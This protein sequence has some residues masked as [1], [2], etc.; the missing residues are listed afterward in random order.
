MPLSR[1][2][3]RLI[4]L[5]VV[6]L[7]LLAIVLAM[8]YVHH[9]HE[10]SEMQAA[11]IVKGAMAAIDDNLSARIAGLQMLAKSP[12]GDDAAHWKALYQQAQGYRDSFGSH[13]VLADA[14]MHMRFN[15]RVPFGA[16]LPALPQPSGR[17]AAKTARDTLKPA[18]GDPFM[19]PIAGEPLVAIAAPSIRDE[20]LSHMLLTTIE[21]RLL[22]AT[23][24]QMVL[25]AGWAV[26]L[27]DSADAVIARHG[28]AQANG[29]AAGE[30]AQRFVGKS[31]LAPWSV[32]L[33]IPR[34]IYF[35]PVIDA[36]IALVLAVLIATTL[37]FLG[38]KWA[39]RRLGTAVASL[40]EAPGQPR[41][42]PEI[43]EI[44]HARR[45]LD[46]ALAQRNQ[47]EAARRDS[48]QR[49]RTQIE[50]GAH[51]VALSESRLRG[52]FDSA[53]DTILTADASQTII[54]ANPAAARM[55][56]CSLDRL[57]GAPLERL[58]PARYHQQH[59]RDV[60]AF[61]DTDVQ[62]RQMA[63]QRPVMGLRSD[64]E[65]FPIEAAISHLT[66]DGQRLYTVILRDITQRVRD[67]AALQR[68]ADIVETSGDAIL[69]RLSDGT[70]VTWN[71]AAQQLF[72]YTQEEMV[73]SSVERLYSPHTKP[74]ERNLAARVVRGER[75]VNIDTLR[76]HKDGT[77]IPVAITMSAVRDQHGT[78]VATTAILR[79]IT[80][81]I[82]MDAELER[83]LR[84]Q[85]QAEATMR[86]SRD[87]L[88]ELSS[89]LQTIREDEKTRIAREL[90]DELGQA[91]TALKMDAA[92]ITSAL[93]PTAVALR[94]RTDD[95]TQ[96]ID[97][98]VMSVRRIAADLR[99]V[100]L[101]NLGLVPTLEWLAKDFAQRTGIHV[102]LDIDDENLEVEGDPATAVFRIAQEAL[103]NVARHSGADF[104][105]IQLRCSGGQIMLRIQD[106][107][108]GF[109]ASDT[110]KSRSF[111]L[112]GMRE[113]ALVLGG[114]LKISNPLGGGTLIEAFIPAFGKTT[115]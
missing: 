46:E 16:P 8:I 25:P 43:T 60:Q 52:I 87:Q 15:T 14:T 67:R 47:A 70:I 73:G 71:R 53:T 20:K 115:D 26:T 66:V 79:D 28:P 80:A 90:H 94:K 58:I 110:R 31:V 4:L 99:P 59:R 22:E 49:A 98:T 54:M 92:A 18:V 62:N 113:R 32:V 10:E 42:T 39:A 11:G 37:A 13:V 104:V 82:R 6:P 9:V 112:V 24:E 100:I 81:R 17:S 101:D 56:R 1:F 23:L 102:D 95:M 78:V 2:L 107:G 45:M 65:E 7:V 48:E 3:T 74:E 111:G 51:Q 5:C 33:E 114:E 38:G 106:N 21:T 64:G 12:L 88:R 108:K 68:Y 109:T 89:A 86:E 36:A 93:D 77:D 91:L 44:N 76:R 75:I 103:T 50:Q 69:S 30:G 35:A 72:G 41:P 84:E 85:R 27:R 19:G 55:F 105:G 63:A 97:T 29:D 61:G 57:I 96:L 40:A 83:L 34:M